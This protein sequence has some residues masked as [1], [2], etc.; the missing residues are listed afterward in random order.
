VVRQVRVR[1]E[2]GDIFFKIVRAAGYFAPETYYVAEGVIEGAGDGSLGRAKKAIEKGTGRFEQ[3]R[4]SRAIDFVEGASWSF[5]TSEVKGTKDLS[6]LKL[7]IML[8][9]NWER[10][11]ISLPLASFAQPGF[12]RRPQVVRGS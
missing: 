2:A 7:L 3:A 6:G 9:A 8:L 10:V 1:G 12:P 5:D 11:I 4:F